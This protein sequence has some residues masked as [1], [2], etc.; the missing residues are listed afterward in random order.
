MK[1][2]ACERSMSTSTH[3]LTQAVACSITSGACTSTS[4]QIGYALATHSCS[5]PSASFCASHRGWHCGRCSGVWYQN[6][7]ENSH[8]QYSNV[9]ASTLSLVRRPSYASHFMYAPG[10]SMSS[11]LASCC[12]SSGGPGAESTCLSSSPSLAW[13][14]RRLSQRC[15]LCLLGHGEHGLKGRT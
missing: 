14:M 6:C 12:S 2:W 5:F 8:C 13:C 7:C 1:P 10:S 11:T 15:L 9:T 3:A 4:C